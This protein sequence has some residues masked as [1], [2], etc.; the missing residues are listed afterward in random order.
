MRALSQQFNQIK[1]N[2]LNNNPKPVTTVVTLDFPIVLRP[3]GYDEP[4]VKLCKHFICNQN[5]EK[6]RQKPLPYFTHHSLRPKG[7]TKKII[8]ANLKNALR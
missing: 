8:A 6:N 3:K 7:W 1:Y 2:F 5:V 4:Q